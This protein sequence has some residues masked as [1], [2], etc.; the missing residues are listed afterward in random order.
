MFKKIAATLATLVCLSGPQVQA[1][2]YNRELCD[3][4]SSGYVVCAKQISST[5]DRLG[6]F[7][8]SGAT[9]FIGDITCTSDQYILHSGWVGTVTRS[10]AGEYAK[11]YCQGR[12]NMF[13]SL[14]SVLA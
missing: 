1:Q 10:T 12:G 4:L 5:I 14:P 8:P 7:T 3:T 6:V 11:A 13:A 9:E 2:S